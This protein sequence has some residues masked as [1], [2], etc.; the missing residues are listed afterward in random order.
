MASSVELTC[1]VHGAAGHVS[2]SWSSTGSED[3]FAQGIDNQSVSALILR[4]ADSGSHTCTATDFVGQDCN[5][6]TS[7]SVEMNI[8]GKSCFCVHVTVL[9]G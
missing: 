8:V 1:V 9:Q 4:P 5:R 7:A 2:Y 6:T 3:C